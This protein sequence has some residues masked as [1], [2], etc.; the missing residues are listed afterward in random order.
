MN[1]SSGVWRSVDTAQESYIVINTAV[2]IIV[3]LIRMPLRDDG[4]GY[5]GWGVRYQ[6]TPHHDPQTGASEILVKREKENDWRAEYFR[7]QGESLFWQVPTLS[8]RFYE[9]RAM[10]EDLLPTEAREYSSSL[11]EQMT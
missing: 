11:V 5:T 4:V 10:R 6:L 1:F 2:E 7:C 8:S 9:W 3:N